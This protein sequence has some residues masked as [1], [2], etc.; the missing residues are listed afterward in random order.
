MRT[1]W[2]YDLI[3][4]VN[5]LSVPPYSNVCAVQVQRGVPRIWMF[6]IPNIPER[7]VRRFWV[8]GTGEDI[9]DTHQYYGTFQLEGG[10]LVF[11]VF[12]EEA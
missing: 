10:D 6:V 4:G 2:K 5:E 9:P 7:V 1:I 3:P 12:E 11:H 8:Y